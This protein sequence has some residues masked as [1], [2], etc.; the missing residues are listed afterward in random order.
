MKIASSPI[1]LDSSA[2]AKLYVREPDSDALEEVLVGRVDLLISLLT[3]TEMTSAVARRVREKAFR[4]LVARRIYRQLLDH[5]AQQRFMTIAAGED[6]HREAERLLFTIG[7]R[8]PL[9]AGDSLHLATAS[10]AG[11]RA[12]VTFD[13]RLA[14][15]AEEL[16]TFELFGSVSG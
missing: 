11:A 6:A 8:I 9:R 4:P 15:A 12:V 2:L 10:L 5:V 14:A 7:S 16:G 13:R 3:I 1:Y